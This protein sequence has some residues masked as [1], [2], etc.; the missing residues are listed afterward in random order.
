MKQQARLGN[1]TILV[2]KSE[3]SK[4]DLDWINPKQDYVPK[5]IKLSEIKYIN[6]NELKDNPLNSVFKQESPEYFDKLKND[7][8][9]HG[10]LVPL[11]AKH[12]GLILAGHNRWR[13]ANEL[14]L[15]KVPVQ[16]I[17]SDLNTQEE[18]ELIFKDNILRRQLDAKDKEEIIK[19]LYI[20]EIG[21]DNRGG[22]RKSS[23]I[24][25]SG[26]LLIFDEHNQ[27]EKIK[28]SSE[29]LIV[30]PERIESETGIKAGTAKRILAKIRKEKQ[31]SVVKEKQPKTGNPL[32]N[33]KKLLNAIGIILQEE[34]P[35]VLKEAV[36]QIELLISFLKNMSN[37]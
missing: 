27:Y 30:L 21:Q 18:R 37:K 20:R 2:K 35:E 12:D 6:T 19:K 31:E 7:I 26:E 4:H 28:I 13:V 23:K 9:K 3:T 8:Y 29:L 15:A 22:D 14:N 36:S 1:K 33:I 16:Y 24:K 11:I 5:G 10:I 34:K 25:S 32:N 17:E